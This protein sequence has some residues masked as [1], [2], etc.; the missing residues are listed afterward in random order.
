MRV[1][2][3]PRPHRRRSTPASSEAGESLVELMITVAIM[4]VSMVA[5]LGAIWTTLRVADYNSKASNA[6]VVLRAYAETMQ[7]PDAGDEFDYVP[8]TTAGGQV[9]YPAYAPPAPYEDYDATV[10]DVR[11]LNGYTAGNEPVW[12]DTCLATDQGLQEIT[13]SVTGP[14][15]DPEVTSTETVTVLKRDARDDVPLGST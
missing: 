13:L 6:D 8:C 5:I 2:P 12:S 14:V 10:T 4:G 3:T 15:D 11:Y 7:Q 1:A 9:T